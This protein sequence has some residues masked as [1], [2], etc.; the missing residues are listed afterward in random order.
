MKWSGPRINFEFM[1]CPGCKTS[2]SSSNKAVSKI[3]NDNKKVQKHINKIALKRAKHEG[4]DKDK[5]LKEAPY[6]GELQ[7]YA[8][9]RL[10][11]YMCFKCV[12]PYFGGLKS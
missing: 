5:R 11:Y 8:V 6:N 2:I 1:K 4:I 9:A 12:K 7:S 10:S 3:I